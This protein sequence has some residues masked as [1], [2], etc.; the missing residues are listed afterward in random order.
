MPMLGIRQKVGRQP[1]PIPKYRCIY[2]L[3]F[4]QILF[5][6]MKMKRRLNTNQGS[7]ITKYFHEFITMKVEVNCESASQKL[8]KTDQN[9]AK[10]TIT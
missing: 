5:Y 10:I 3:S 6:G 1:P 2:K 8:T 9:G 7:E 4:C